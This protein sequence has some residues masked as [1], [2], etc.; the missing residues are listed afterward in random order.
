MCSRV[1]I[2]KI[3]QITD[4][5]KPTGYDKINFIHEQCRKILA[6]RERQFPDMDLG[7]MRICTDMQ[8]Y[9]VNWPQKALRKTVQFRAIATSC[10]ETGDVL[11]YHPQIDTRFSTIEVQEMVL[12]NGDLNLRPA[13]QEFT[14]LCNFEDC[15]RALKLPPHSFRPVREEQEMAE[16]MTE[17]RQ[18]PDQGALIHIDY[19]A[20]AISCF[21]PI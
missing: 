1:S 16:H 6:D 19:L 10:L 8:D 9:M 12:D 2:A 7:D 3:A 15:A 17:D 4:L 20:L 14:R 21:S 5:P 18:L 11:A 13:F